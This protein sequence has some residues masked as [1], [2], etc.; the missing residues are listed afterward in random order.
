[1]MV[2]LILLMGF[3]KSLNYCDSLFLERARTAGSFYHSL[4][5]IES[6]GTVSRHKAQSLSPTRTNEA[7]KKGFEN[8][9]A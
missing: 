8:R 4:L 7:Q 1:M 3:T 2:R 6:F 5:A 9:A